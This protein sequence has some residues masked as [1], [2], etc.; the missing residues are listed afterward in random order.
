M[1]CRPR[2]VATRT[3]DLK[4]PDN[5]TS[6]LKSSEET[7]KQIKIRQTFFAGLLAACVLTGASAASAQ[8][9]TPQ[10]GG[11]QASVLADAPTVTPTREGVWGDIIY[12]SP[13]APV[14]LIEYGSL[15]CP[16]CA[17]FSEDV[18]PRLMQDY[19]N[20]GKLR[21]VFRNFVRDRYDLAAAAASRCLPDVDA[22]KRAL[23][24]LFAEQAAWL[25]SDNPYAAIADIVGREGLSQE[26]MGQ[27]ISDQDVRV[28]IVQMTQTGAKDFDIKAI[29]T[30][31]LNGNPMTFPGYDL[32]TVRIDAQLATSA[33]GS[34]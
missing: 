8:S 30:L 4:W 10:S 34:E 18:L 19:I 14:E 33:P 16:H 20:D 6:G 17:S 28:H 26:A 23:K 11:Q 21:F 22:T 2:T 9:S 1:S 13:D 24:S 25:Q 7:M 31:V 5:R 27:C 29:P 15:T 12:G 32:L 3:N